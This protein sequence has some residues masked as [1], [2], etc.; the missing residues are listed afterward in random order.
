[1][2]SAIRAIPRRQRRSK[3]AC[4][5]TR[6][7]AARKGGD[8]APAVVPGK[9]SESLLLKALRYDSAVQMPPKGK[10]SDQV[11]ADFEKWIADGAA[12]PRENSSPAV[13]KSVDFEKA[14]KFWSYQ[15]PQ[16][17]PP[18][19][20]GQSSWPVKK[21]DSFVLSQLQRAGLQPASAADARTFIGAYI[22]I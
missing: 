21:I 17:H 2:S 4:G 14:K 18:P 9:T 7:E 13:A 19:Q 3:A 12:D 10:L 1:M 11:I 20:V 15:P 22:S 6:R 5:W 16:A 8:T